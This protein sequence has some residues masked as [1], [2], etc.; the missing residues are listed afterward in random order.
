MLDYIEQSFGEEPA[1]SVIWLHGLGADGNDFAPIVPELELP[2]NAAVRFIFPHAPQQPVTINGGMVMRAWYDIL[3]ME[4]A[5]QVDE[6]GIE[7]SSQ[8]V[9]ELIDHEMDRGIRNENII[10]AGF[11]QGGAIA[12]HTALLYDKPLLGILALSTYL[13]I[14][15]RIVAGDNPTN[16]SIPIFMG[17]GTYDPVVP[18]QLGHQ[19]FEHLNNQGYDVEWHTYP[20]Q[21]AVNMEEIRDVGAWMGRL[22]QSAPSG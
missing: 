19:S 22:L 9:R 15:H 4:I 20:I 5:R 3:S 12:L 10:V 8:Y 17:H 16:E 6:A 14:P 11:S 7:R 21:H 18:V 1:F 2:S 13:P